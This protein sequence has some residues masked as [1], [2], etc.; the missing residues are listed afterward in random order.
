M[1]PPPTMTTRACWGSSCPASPTADFGAAP[2]EILAALREYLP[3]TSELHMQL[4]A[5]LDTPPGA[6]P[7]ELRFDAYD[8][9]T[10]GE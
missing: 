7:V 10:N 2:T 3:P 5:L 9:A 4:S 1:M 8:W 6:P